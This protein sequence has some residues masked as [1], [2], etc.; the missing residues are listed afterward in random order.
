VA[1]SDNTPP[2][3]CSGGVLSGH[4][5]SLRYELFAGLRLVSMSMLVICQ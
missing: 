2:D 4:L 3:S 1:E 5:R